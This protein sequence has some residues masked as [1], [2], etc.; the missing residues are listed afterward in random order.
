MLPCTK[1][2][3]KLRD[4]LTPA[5]QG[6]HTDSH[7]QGFLTFDPTE[8]QHLACWVGYKTNIMG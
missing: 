6:F 1:K 3:K 4:H 8:N 2:E 7:W 5:Q